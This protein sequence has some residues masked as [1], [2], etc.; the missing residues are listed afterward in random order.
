MCYV[1]SRKGEKPKGFF[2]GPTGNQSPLGGEKK[3]QSYNARNLLSPKKKTKGRKQFKGSINESSLR[4]GILPK[5]REKEQEFTLERVSL[6]G[7]GQRQRTAKETFK[8]TT[9]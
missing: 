9:T 1:K 7:R 4:A 2:R 8:K 3:A 6:Q 5:E